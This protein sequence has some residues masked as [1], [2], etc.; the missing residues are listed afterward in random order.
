MKYMKHNNFRFFAKAMACVALML[1]VMLASVSCGKDLEAPEGMKLA[2][3]DNVPYC[4]YV[5]Q[6][7]V[8]DDKDN[9]SSAYYSAVDPSNVTVTSYADSMSVESYWE[10]CLA[11]YAASL[12]DFK[13]DESKTGTRSMGGKEAKQYVYT[14]TFNG[15]KYKVAQTITTRDG[16]VYNFTYT[17]TD[18]YTD[19]EG[20]NVE[21]K[22]D[23]HY[24]EAEKILSAF[25]F[26]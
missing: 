18:S 9:T 3:D 10:L 12:A 14:F 4:L 21:G 6:A 8:T 15:V 13:V 17:S 7:W 22:F 16:I 20:K 19:A 11:D 25:K 26:R 1:V 5:P 24:A 23:S 2:S